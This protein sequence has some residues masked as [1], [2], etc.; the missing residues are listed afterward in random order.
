MGSPLVPSYLT[1]GDLER[2]KVKVTE[3]SNSSFISRT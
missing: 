1:L 2:S 3:V